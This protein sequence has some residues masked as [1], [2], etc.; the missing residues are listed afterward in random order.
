MEKTR[1]EVG[2]LIKLALPVSL[3]QLSLVG[4]TATDVLIAGNAS[5]LDLAGMNLGANTWNMVALFFMGVGFATQPL[6]ANYFGAGDDAAVKNQMQ[7]S[8][9]L[10]LAMGVLCTFIPSKVPRMAG[11][12][13]NGMAQSDITKR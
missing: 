1:A 13:Q 5:T 11:C 9:W 10:C 4:M 7:Q 12:K 8:I 3:A 2:A 6:V